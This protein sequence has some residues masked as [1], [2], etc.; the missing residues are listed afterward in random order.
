MIEPGRN[1][2][3]VFVV[4]LLVMCLAAPSLACPMDTGGHLVK[5]NVIDAHTTNYGFKWYN[6]VPN[7]TVTAMGITIEQPDWLSSLFGITPNIS[8]IESTE[9]KGITDEYGVVVLP[10]Y[11]AMLYNLTVVCDGKE[12]TMTIYPSESE[13][14][15]YIGKC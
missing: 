15:L 1:D 8:E 7:A 2:I 9:Q 5:F 6:P 10:L 12:T 4:A 11:K 14:K 13:Y 3:G